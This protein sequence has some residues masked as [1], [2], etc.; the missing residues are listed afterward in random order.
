MGYNEVVI[1][2]VRFIYKAGGRVDGFT[3]LIHRQIVSLLK[4]FIKI[5]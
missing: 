3:G 2:T 1:D 5:S 4:Y